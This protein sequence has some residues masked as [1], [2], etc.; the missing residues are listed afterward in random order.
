MSASDTPFVING[1]F[2]LEDR[3]ENEGSGVVLWV[4]GEHDAAD[5]PDLSAVLASAADLSRGEVVVDLSRVT[6]M[7]AA[8]IGAIVG[9]RNGLR[10]AGRSLTLRAPSRCAARLLDLCA[11]PCVDST[12][13][14]A[15]G[16]RP[17]SALGSW[18]SVPSLPR[19]EASRP[20][21]TE[22]TTGAPVE[23]TTGAPVETREQASVGDGFV[24]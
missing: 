12:E 23:T 1:S 15:E 8:T 2:L 3:A 10:L 21:P 17:Q 20:A 22:P 13:L 18:V 14:P 7:S 4:V 16:P 9:S 24:T 5:A 6:F 19:A 11:I